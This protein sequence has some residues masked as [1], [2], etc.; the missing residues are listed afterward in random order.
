VKGDFRKYE[1]DFRICKKLVLIDA[2]VRRSASNIAPRAAARWRA[3]VTKVLQQFPASGLERDLAGLYLGE[4]FRKPGHASTPL[5]YTNFVTSLDGR[6]AVRDPDSRRWRVPREI[7]TPEDHRLYQELA[8]QAD[9]VLVTPRHA[10]AMVDRPHLCPFPYLE[11]STDSTLKRWRLDRKLPASPALVVVCLRPKFP[12]RQL[13]ERFGCEVICITGQQAD[14]EA[15]RKLEADGV[16]VVTVRDRSFVSGTEL[17]EALTRAGHYSIYSVAGPSLFGTLLDSRVLNRLYL[18]QVDRIVG[19]QEFQTFC[20]LERSPA[21]VELTLRAEYRCE[22]A[23]APGQT[24][25][26]FD[27]RYRG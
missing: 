7:E 26:V 8:A 6:I 13:I 15:L 21:H 9:A 16:T 23:E 4:P 5:V 14:K 18:N 1:I 24:F 25:R 19:G 22:P 3:S 11:S 10:R 20:T 27:L 17:I 12:G 2:P